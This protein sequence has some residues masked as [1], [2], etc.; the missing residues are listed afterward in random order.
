MAVVLITGGSRGIGAATALLAA[1]RGYGVCVSYRRQRD[2]ANAVVEAIRQ[3]GGR[4]IALQADI[5]L[6]LDIINLFDAVDNQLGKVTALVN[7]AGIL[8]RQMRVDEMDADRLDRVFSTNI[9]GTFL[10]AREAI[11][12]MSTKH[13]GAGGGDCKCL[14]RSLSF[15]LSKRIC[16]LCRF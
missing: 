1:E 11:K 16:R 4:A 12:R 6:E 10:C 7:N 5:S 8:E 2:K 14:I 13:G 3:K 9:K 15:R